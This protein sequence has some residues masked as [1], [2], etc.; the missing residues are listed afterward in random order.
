MLL[1]EKEL[2]AV[3]DIV[4]LSNCEFKLDEYDPR[5]IDPD[6]DALDEIRWFVYR[7]EEAVDNL[8]EAVSKEGR[9]REEILD[10]M[11]PEDLEQWEAEIGAI[12]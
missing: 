9:R 12:N 7:L 6:D 3:L 4:A 1:L 5:N 8:R 10:N 2:R 11:D